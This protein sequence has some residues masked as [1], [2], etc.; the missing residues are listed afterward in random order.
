M[1][2]YTTV[3]V[4][5]SALS[6]ICT[7]DGVRSGYGGKL[8]NDDVFQQYDLVFPRR[9]THEGEFLSHYLPTVYHRPRVRKKAH[10][11]RRWA[12]DTV[13]YV[14]PIRDREHHVE[15][16]PN[17]GFISPGMVVER[18]KKDINDRIIDRVNETQC[19][20]TGFI[21]GDRDSKVAISTCHGLTGYIRTKRHYFFIEPAEGHHRSQRLTEQFAQ[22]HYVKINR[23]GI[24]NSSKCE[25]F[26]DIA[27]VMAKRSGLRSERGDGNQ[28][29]PELHIET[30]VVLDHSMLDYHKD[31]DLENYVLTVFNMAHDLFHDASLGT[32]IDLAIVR[33]IRLEEE[34]HEMNMNVNKDAE[35]TLEYFREWQNQVNPKEDTHPNHHDIAVLITRVDICGADSTCGLLGSSKIGGMCDPQNQAAICEDN[36]LRLGFVIAHEIAHTLAILHDTPEESGCSGI[37]LNNLTTVMNPSISIKTAGWSNCSNKFLSLFVESGFGK[38]LYDPPTEHSFKPVDILPGVMYD[39]DFQCREVMGPNAALCMTGVD[40]ENLICYIE[41]KGCVETHTGVAPGTKCGDKK[42]CFHGVCIQV[43]ERE[44]AIDG[45]WGTW[46]EWSDCSRTC[47][48]GVAWQERHCDSPAPANGGRYCLGERKRHKICATEPCDANLPSF[49][50]VQCIEFNS[51]VYPED[52]KVHT[53]KNYPM[54]DENPCVLFCINDWG[55]IASLRPRVIDGT[56]CQRGM[57]D[58]CIDGLCKE[59]PCDLDLESNAVE[60]SC[61]VCRGDSTSCT[62]IKGDITVPCTGHIKEERVLNIPRSASNIKVEEMMPTESRIQIRSGNGETVFI[63]GNVI[64][65][66]NVPGTYAWVG[67]IRSKQEAIAIPGPLSDEISLWLVVTENVT[68][69]YSYGIPAKKKRI[70]SFSWDYLGWSPCSAACGPGVQEAVPSCTEKVGGM[71]DDMYC[72]YAP[73]PIVQIRACERAPCINRWF[74]GDWGPC[75]K[76]PKGRRY[77]VVKCIRPTGEGEGEVVYIS[78]SNCIGPKPKSW[79]SC[80]C[81][82]TNCKD[83]QHKHRQIRSQF[84]DNK[85]TPHIFSSPIA[86]SPSLGFTEKIIQ[87]SMFNKYSNSKGNNS[88]ISTTSP[89]NFTAPHCP[90]SFDYDDSK[91]EEEY[92]NEINS[93]NQSGGDSGGG[94]RNNDGDNKGGLNTGFGGDSDVLSNGRPNGKLKLPPGAI[95]TCIILINETSPQEE[96]TTPLSTTILSTILIDN[97]TLSNNLTTIQE[98]CA[99]ELQFRN[100][101]AEMCAKIAALMGKSTVDKECISNLSLTV[102]T[103]LENG[104][105]PQ[106]LPPLQHYEDNK[107]PTYTIT[108]KEAIKFMSSMQKDFENNRTKIKKK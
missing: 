65:S 78:D 38:C 62:V 4:I 96:S 57:R 13:H 16:H 89:I 56:S 51:W 81:Y 74:V 15:L 3:V 52:E 85:S 55:D 37:Y 39:G 29:I 71:V 22:P 105:R 59:I 90:T 73:R 107:N 14:I 5:C 53:W 83:K 91:E 87:S 86:D 68:I 98:T 21:R 92:E 77:R 18:F 27:K 61:G 8:R 30:L 32:N 79:E 69:S 70:P 66:F 54:H 42:W 25:T 44:G 58:I 63:V 84:S 100:E 35:K 94:G 75:K 7:V 67:N 48:S 9:V 20:Y 31:I 102:H 88:C 46:S 12:K 99:T 72:K 17:T 10:R 26:D 104:K 41:D 93:Q 34:D 64:G 23:N 36:G 76:C 19:H 6:F 103:E 80:T 1:V 2:H 60:D 24:S 50:D 95:T 45:G 106:G 49:R 108:G 97:T 28:C 101:K 82:D 33:I 11:S 40:C 47:G 43:G